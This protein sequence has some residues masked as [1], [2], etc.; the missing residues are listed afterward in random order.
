MK[1]YEVQVRT[2]P[3]RKLSFV[4]KN[5]HVLW[6]ESERRFQGEVWSWGQTQR[7]FTG[8]LK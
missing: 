8:V 6:A 4:S 3:F 2:A 7:V 1:D 5:E